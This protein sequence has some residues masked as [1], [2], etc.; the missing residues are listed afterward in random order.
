[1]TRLRLRSVAAIVT[2]ML[3]A[4]LLRATAANATGSEADDL[5]EI[6]ES[7]PTA[8]PVMQDV[9]TEGATEL[10]APGTVS[11][12]VAAIDDV[13]T[14]SVAALGEDPMPVGLLAAQDAVAVSVSHSGVEVIDNGNNS[15]T[16]PLHREDGSLQVVFVIQAPDAPAT[17][18]IDVDLPE[19]VVLTQESDGA[20]LASAADG[21]LVLGVAPAWAFDAAGTAVPTRYV[22]EGSEITQVVEH[23]SGDYQYPISADPWLGVRLFDPMRL[24]RQGKFANKNVYSGQLT[25]WGVAMGLSAGGYTI[26]STAGLEEFTS[27][28]STVRNSTSLRQQYLCHALWGRTI[29]GAGINCDLELS[30]PANANYANVFAHRCN[31]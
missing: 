25:A 6:L 24:N 11:S 14:V 31:W 17:Y 13:S 12:D 3:A 20:L 8:I 7:V 27:Q 30:R 29:I 19:G 2:A 21:Q 4:S 23:A 5:V 22:V 28:W 26:L 18:S 15:S 10:V 16:V 9:S 1:M